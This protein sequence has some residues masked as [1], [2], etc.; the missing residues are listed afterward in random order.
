MGQD[1]R[2]LEYDELAKGREIRTKKGEG[3]TGKS[4]TGACAVRD[5][6]YFVYVIVSGAYKTTFVF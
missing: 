1:R 5:A 4:Y 3:Q 6:K 2:G